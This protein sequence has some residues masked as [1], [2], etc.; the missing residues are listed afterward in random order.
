MI[1]LISAGKAYRRGQSDV[2]ALRD[3]DLAVRAGELLVILGPSGSGKSTL[4]NLIGGMDRPSSG[5]VKLRGQSIAQASDAELTEFRRCEVGFVFQFYN[6]IPNLTALENVQ[7]AADIAPCP[8]NSEEFLGRVGLAARWDHFPAELS[9][10][11]QQRVAVA[12]ALVGDPALL[13]CDEPTGALDEATSRDVLQLL[14]ELADQGKAVVIITHDQVI[15]QLAD[16]IINLQHGAIVRRETNAAPISVG[17][18]RWS[19]S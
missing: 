3:A 18:L 13:L 2:I 10:G 15:S 11:E 14:R 4:V 1:E 8:L 17:E 6:L 16:R 5:D 19:P 7:V 12:R 9:G